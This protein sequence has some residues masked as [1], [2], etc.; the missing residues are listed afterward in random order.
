MFVSCSDGC[1]SANNGN[2]GYCVVA[3]TLDR[4][5]DDYNTPTALDACS[6]SFIC[7]TEVS[8]RCPYGWAYYADDGSEGTDSCVHVST[9][10]V[11]NWTMASQSCPAGSHLLTV[12]ASRP[13]ALLTF[14]NSLYGSQASA[15]I[16]CSQSSL[17]TQSAAGWS[18]IDG[19]SASNLNCGAGSGCSGCGAWGIGEPE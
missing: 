18:W 12:K 16:G 1:L 15:F 14:V 11:S 5:T 7:E 2:A 10:V 17:S 9:Y 4:F 13:S 6:L 8:P 3:P 19:T